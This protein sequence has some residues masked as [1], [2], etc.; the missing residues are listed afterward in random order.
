MARPAARISRDPA[1]TT[2]SWPGAKIEF[3]VKPPHW[4]D[5]KSECDD[6]RLLAA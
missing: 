4:K 2:T 5:G 3:V 1:S 6:I